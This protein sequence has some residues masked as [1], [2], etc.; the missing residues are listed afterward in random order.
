MKELE[1]NNDFNDIGFPWAGHRYFAK[2]LV[3][4]LEPK[5]I[6]ELGTWMGTSMFSMLQGV[7][8]KN[9]TTEFNAI[10]TWTGEKHTGFYEG[11]LILENIKVILQKYYSG[12]KV[13][14]IRSFFDEALNKFENNSIDILHID[15]LH[16]YEAVKHDYNTWQEKLTPNGVILFHDIMVRNFDF[17]VYQLWDELIEDK[18]NFCVS[19]EHSNGLGILTK[20]EK[21]FEKICN[22]IDKNQIIYH[23]KL[24]EELTSECYKLNNQLTS[25]YNSKYWK[26]K[27]T[28]KQILGKK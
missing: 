19:F 18:K 2:D 28:L 23:N 10:D 5:V 16:T 25:I 13:N 9:L 21:Q 24:N 15:G 4:T 1:Y 7:K 17:G 27:E 20:S 22:L 12:C 14:L 3:E 11:N 6:V 8:N 26:Y